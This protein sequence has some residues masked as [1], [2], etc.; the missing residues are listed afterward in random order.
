MPRESSGWF[1]GG[2]EFRDWLLE[3]FEKKP[4][5]ADRNVRS[6]EQARDYSVDR[7]EELIATGLECFGLEEE[8]LKEAKGG[9]PRRLLIAGAI[10]K[11]TTVGQGWIAQRLGM[12]TAGNV[13]QQLRRGL[14][15]A[16][17]GISKRQL[18]KWEKLSRFVT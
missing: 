2:E 12:R 17:E 3:R 11:Q 14:D 13:S 6:S 18:K 15:R 9:D 16:K 5:Q 8:E 4:S 7:A 10:W 1:R